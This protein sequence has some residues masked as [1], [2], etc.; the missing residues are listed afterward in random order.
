VNK[1]LL[2]SL[3]A[4]RTWIPGILLALGM[5]IGLLAVV[6]NY[7]PAAAS[8]SSGA[9]IMVS[10]ITIE[11]QVA[12]PVVIQME[13]PKPVLKPQRPRPE[14]K[15]VLS[16]AS[17]APAASEV[18][19]P[20]EPQPELAMNSPSSGPKE[21]P[22]PPPIILPHTDANY[23]NNPILYPRKSQELSEQGTT[24]LRAH[25][26]PDGTVSD[27]EMINSSGYERLDKA[28][29]ESVKKWKFVPG[30]QG[31]TPVAAWV[32]VPVAFSL[33]KG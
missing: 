33:K 2:H 24:M 16:T 15:T 5:H 8:L 12:Q 28:A 3:R 32:R 23:L 10:L 11:P 7:Q 14:K 1:T 30:K 19:P 31:G 29:I 18:A 6:W 25:V 22:G 20:P 21:E 27:V 4:P 26:T 9:P 17:I 13:P